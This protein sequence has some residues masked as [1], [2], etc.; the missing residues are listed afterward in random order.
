MN[1]FS[2]TEECYNLHVAK[3]PS[4]LSLGMAF[5]MTE[6]L[7]QTNQNK[8]SEIEMAKILYDF[9]RA[10]AHLFSAPVLFAA[11]T[12]LDEIQKAEQLAI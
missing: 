12:L 5:L 2:Q 6:I 7:R 9:I 11:Q 4:G 1:R 8:D 10:N 3:G